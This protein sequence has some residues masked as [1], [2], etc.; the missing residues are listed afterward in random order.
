MSRGP[1][2][3]IA[4]LSFREQPPELRNYSVR[5]R[6]RLNCICLSRGWMIVVVV[7]L[8]AHDC[9]PVSRNLAPPLLHLFAGWSASRSSLSVSLCLVVVVVLI[10]LHWV[11][12]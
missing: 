2:E 1:S 8:L 7:C 11:L 5:R 9:R 10:W 6:R 4:S 3:L 12:V